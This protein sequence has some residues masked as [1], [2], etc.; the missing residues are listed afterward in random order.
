MTIFTDEHRQELSDYDFCKSCL[1]IY[2]AELSEDSYLLDAISDGREGGIILALRTF[3]RRHIALARAIYIMQDI[4][5]CPPSPWD[6]PPMPD[7]F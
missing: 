7:P 2:H 3:K 6:N 5:A 4:P 1:Q